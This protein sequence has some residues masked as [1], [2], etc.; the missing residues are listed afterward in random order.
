DE[1]HPVRDLQRAWRRGLDYVDDPVRLLARPGRL[2]SRSFRN[3]GRGHRTDQFVTGDRRH[4]EA[5]IGETKGLVGRKGQR[6]RRTLRRTI[7]GEAG[8]AAPQI[9]PSEVF[10]PETRPRTPAVTPP[11]EDTLVRAARREA[12]LALGV[13]FVAMLYS[14]TYC[15]LNGYGR[16]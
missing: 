1:L 2:D 15:Y 4:G 6:Q 5:R 16:S 14:V 11:R 13:W 3:H 10:C 12:S 7:W 8:E 9:V